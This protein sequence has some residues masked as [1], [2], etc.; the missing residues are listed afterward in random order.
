MNVIDIRFVVI[1]TVSGGSVQYLNSVQSYASLNMT[2]YSYRFASSLTIFTNNSIDTIFFSSISSLIAQ[3][4]PK[5]KGERRLSEKQR[6]PQRQLPSEK[7]R[8]LEK[9]NV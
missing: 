4:E 1:L 9:Q 3:L 6:F 5:W 2:T 7:F 8:N